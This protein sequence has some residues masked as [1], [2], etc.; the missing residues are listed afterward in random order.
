MPMKRLAATGLACL[1]S[2]CQSNLTD[3]LPNLP[4]KFTDFPATTA[5]DLSHCVHRAAQSKIS[6][7][8]FHLNA[9]ADKMEFVMTATGRTHTTMRPKSSKL[10]LHFITKGESTRVEMEKSALE[11]QELNRDIWLTVERCAQKMPE[12]AAENTSP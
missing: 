8:S 2:A 5:E 1:L 4:E 10:E 7:Y 3:I 11:D 6:P 9:R 12:H